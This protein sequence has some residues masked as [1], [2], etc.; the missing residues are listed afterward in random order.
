MATKR[1]QAAKRKKP[2]KASKQGAGRKKKLVRAASK[3]AVERGR[4]E[5]TWP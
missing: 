3:K 4:C 1:K 2:T 5:G